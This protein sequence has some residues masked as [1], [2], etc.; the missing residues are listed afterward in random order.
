MPFFTSF[1]IKYAILLNLYKKSHPR[2]F[3]MHRE[4]YYYVISLTSFVSSY[5]RNLVP[6]AMPV[7]RLGWHW[8]WGNGMICVSAYHLIGFYFNDNDNVLIE[9]AFQG[10]HFSCILTFSCW[11]LLNGTKT[12]L[13]TLHYRANEPLL[14]YY[15]C[16]LRQAHLWHLSVAV[17]INYTQLNTV[18]MSRIHLAKVN[19][20]S[21]PSGHPKDHLT[22]GWLRLWV[23]LCK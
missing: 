16:K 18:H 5:H 14:E 13:S 15:C 2:V 12:F 1:F 19:T 23:T 9:W 20:I 7:P 11:K 6:R 22:T 10:L 8:L 3:S 21:C 17:S 4:V